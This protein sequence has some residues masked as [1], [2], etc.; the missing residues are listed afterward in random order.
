MFPETHLYEGFRYVGA[1]PSIAT[2]RQIQASILENINRANLLVVGCG[3]GEEIDQILS[4][5]QTSANILG[6]TAIDLADVEPYLF[7]Q[8]N[9]SSLGKK[10]TFKKHNIFDIDELDGFGKYDIVQCGFVLH[11]FQ[12]DQKEIAI[13]LLASAVRLGGYVMISDIFTSTQQT[14]SKSAEIYDNFIREA[15]TATQMG[16]MKK[17]E[18]EALMGDGECLGLKRTRFEAVNGERDYFEPVNILVERAKR[19]GLKIVQIIENPQNEHLS[20]CIFVRR[21]EDREQI[22]SKGCVSHVV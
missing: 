14:P 3:F 5:R 4:H 15:Y 12:P 17:S 6:V 21:N 8:P 10:F 16:H 22:W 13:A 20:I 9:I 18:F 7:E 11:D 19:V 2:Q 1:L